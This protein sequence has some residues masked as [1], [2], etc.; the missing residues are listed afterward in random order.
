MD[1]V[2][3]VKVESVF[4]SRNDCAKFGRHTREIGYPVRRDSSDPSLTVLLEYGVTGLR[5]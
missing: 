4:V 1:A 5:G 3:G 2:A